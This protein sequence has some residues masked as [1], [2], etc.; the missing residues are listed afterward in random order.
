[1][2]VEVAVCCGHGMS[3]DFGFATLIYINIIQISSTPLT[4]PVESCEFLKLTFEIIRDV[5]DVHISTY[6]NGYVYLCIITS[7]V[8]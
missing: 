6:Y 8:C 5:A 1:M 3:S 2:A 4:I 7:N